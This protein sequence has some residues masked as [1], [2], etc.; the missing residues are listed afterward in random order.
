MRPLANIL[1]MAGVA[2][3]L[4]AIPVDVLLA[5]NH[6]KCIEQTSGCETI[7]PFCGQLGS[8]KKCDA[9]TKDFLCTDT[10]PNWNCNP[11][12]EIECGKL[13]VIGC[14]GEVCNIAPWINTGIDCDIK[15]KSCSNTAPPV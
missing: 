15:A 11:A 2:S 8:C 5:A 6:K 9:V 13:W 3:F 12:A 4:Y 1:L 14:T 10:Y 7:R